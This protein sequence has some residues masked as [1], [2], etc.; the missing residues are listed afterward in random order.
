[1][2]LENFISSLPRFPIYWKLLT[3]DKVEDK[4]AS[5][6]KLGGYTRTEPGKFYFLGMKEKYSTLRV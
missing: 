5:W 4:L 3:K 1:M 2:Q 6:R